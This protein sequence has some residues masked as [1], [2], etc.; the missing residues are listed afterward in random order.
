[1]NC[2]LK[3]GDF[4]PGCSHYNCEDDLDNVDNVDHVHGEN[5]S[6]I[7]PEDIWRQSLSKR[8][9]SKQLPYLSCDLIQK[10]LDLSILLFY[11][12]FYN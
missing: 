4:G 5:D 8:N 12:F 11:C 7:E 6:T 3:S 1:M 10:D 2:T 9:I